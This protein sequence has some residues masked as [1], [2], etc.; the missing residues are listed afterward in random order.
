MGGYP[1]QTMS[2]APCPTL[3]HARLRGAGFKMQSRQTATSFA[4][5]GVVR[6][7]YVALP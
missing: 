1:D 6:A 7:K 3:L 5:D 4:M 2:L